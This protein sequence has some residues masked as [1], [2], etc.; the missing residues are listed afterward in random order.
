MADNNL[1]PK[2]NF[3]PEVVAGVKEAHGMVMDKYKT[4][5]K[6]IVSGIKHTFK[7]GKEYGQKD[8]L[9]EGDK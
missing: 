1:G 4:K 7:Q 9:N 6:K 2:S 8:I 5:I 3:I